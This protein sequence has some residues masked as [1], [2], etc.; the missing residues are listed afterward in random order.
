MSA[1]FG[2]DRVVF[3]VVSLIVLHFEFVTKTALTVH[4]CFSCWSGVRMVGAFSASRAALPARSWVGTR[5]WGGIEPGQ[6]ALS[7]WRE[8]LAYHM[9]LYSVIRDGRKEEDGRAFTVVAFIFPR[10]HYLWRSLL[11]WKWLSM[12]MGSS[13]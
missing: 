6:L 9:L 2:W 3:F 13:E 7:D 12:T 8:I 5:S 11:S 4:Q 1:L 10:N